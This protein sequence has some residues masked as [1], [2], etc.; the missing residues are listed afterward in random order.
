MSHV[1]T[2]AKARLL[3][4][5]TLVVALAACSGK[6]ETAPAAPTAPAATA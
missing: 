4:P 3:V 5:L 2:N 6:D 1:N